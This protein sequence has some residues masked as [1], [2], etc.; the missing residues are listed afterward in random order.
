MPE[1]TEERAARER[2]REILLEEHPEV[3]EQYERL[4]PRYQAIAALIRARR[5]GGLTQAQLAE[6]MGVKQSVVSAVE[7]GR[8]SPRLETLSEAARALGCE[9][10]IDFVPHKV[11]A[12]DDG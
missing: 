8:R 2:A 7:S 6:R 1:V 9:L 5:A 12:V 11:P 10:V 3:R 4:K